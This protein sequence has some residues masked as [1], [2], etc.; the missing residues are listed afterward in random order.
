MATANLD[1]RRSHL[2]ECPDCGLMLRQF[3]LPRATVSRCPR[4]DAV[5]ERSRVNPIGRAFALIVTALVLFV[6]ATQLD[7]ITLAVRG[8][9]LGTYL[10]SGPEQLEMNGMWEVGLVVLIT[11][12]AAPLARL[13][14]LTWVFLGLNVANPPQG[15]HVAFRW[16]EKLAPWSMVEVFLLGVFVAYTKLVDL[17]HVE[18]GGAVYALAALML[19]QIGADCVLDKEIVWER[20]EAI[21]S[22]AGRR[23]AARGPLLGCHTCGHVS[24]ATDNCPR[25]GAHLHRRR[26]ASAS[27]TWALLCAAAVLYLPANILPVMTYVSLG[28]GQPNT[29][30]SG[31]VELAKSGMWPLALLVFFA[32]ITVPVLKLVGLS[33][34]LITTRRRSARGLKRRTAIYR[35]IDSIG[36]WSMIDVFMIS[37]LTALVRMDKLASV[38][39]GA[40]VIAFCSVVILTMFAAMAFDPRIMWDAAG[41]NETPGRGEASGQ[42]AAS[43][44]APEAQ[45]VSDTSFS[46]AEAHA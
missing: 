21:G 34:L 8:R 2:R 22:V 29:I 31:V 17:A 5:L 33:F 32:S 14:C 36:R 42:A 40:G 27:R 16:A 3:P 43:R 20:L 12:V 1:A 13:C 44:P 24:D 28:K 37:I 11:T 6:L 35:V 9:E 25:C 38:F 4:C 23:S 45:P 39:P 18:V 41:M 19:A 10:I 30:L 15:L 7:F 46:D 26:P